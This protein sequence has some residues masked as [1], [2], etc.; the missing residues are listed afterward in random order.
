M[1]FDWWDY[2]KVAQELAEQA[3]DAHPPLQEAMYRASIG[4]AYYAV[5]CEARYH[6]S[7]YDNIPEPD[8]P[9]D[10]NGKRISIHMYVIITFKVSKQNVDDQIRIDLSNILRNMKITREVAD[11]ELVHPWLDMKQLPKQVK[12]NL[13]RANQALTLLN[14][15]QKK[16]I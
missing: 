6:L 14:H 15:L 11:Y 12:T 7:C 10:L 2:L 3:K 8:P 13:N 9:A 4:R 16:H 1:S 5:F